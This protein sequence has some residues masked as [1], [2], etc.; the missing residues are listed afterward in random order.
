MTLD[1]VIAVAL[2]LLILWRGAIMARRIWLAWAA[3]EAKQQREQQKRQRQTFERIM[4]ASTPQAPGL[5]SDH[6][7]VG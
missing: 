7:R 1:M 3:H 2:A 5:R 6:R 4:R